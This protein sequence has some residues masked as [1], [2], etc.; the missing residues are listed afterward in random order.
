MVKNDDGSRTGNPPVSLTDRQLDQ[1][2]GGSN[3][4]HKAF[5]NMPD[6]NF[7]TGWRDFYVNII[8]M[9]ISHCDST[10]HPQYYIALDYR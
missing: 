4:Q 1:V 6:C 5:C 9:A 10:G 3:T 2:A 8:S 7:D